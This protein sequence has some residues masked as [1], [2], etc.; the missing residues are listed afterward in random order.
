M[1]DPTRSTRLQTTQPSGESLESLEQ[2]RVELLYEFKKR[3]NDKGI[4]DKMATTYHCVED[5]QRIRRITFLGK[6]DQYTPKLLSLFRRKGGAVG[7]KLDET[8]DIKMNE[9]LFESFVRFKGGGCKRS[10]DS[11]PADE[12]I[13]QLPTMFLA[14]VSATQSK[15][16][17]PQA[18]LR[19]PPVTYVHICGT[20]VFSMGVFLLR[21]GTSMPL[22]DH[23]DMNGNLRSC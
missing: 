18:E 16:I 10:K 7:R 21:P 3:D 2:V 11:Y 14:D 13:V 8:L 1:R 19:G 20:E 17:S 5:F 6:L 23:P 4:N 22:H 9:S 12:R 15:L